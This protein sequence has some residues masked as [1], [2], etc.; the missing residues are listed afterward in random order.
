MSN[1][2][3]LWRRY[4]QKDDSQAREQLITAYAYLAKYVVDRML[5]RPSSVVGYD[6]LIGHAVVGLIDAV[7]KFDLAKNVKF[8]TY[9]IVRIRGAVL[10]ALKS[11]DWAPRSV[12]ASEQELKRTFAALEAQLGRP[13][14]DAE[15]AAEMGMDVDSLNETIADIGQS[16]MTS[17]EDLM[18]GGEDS[19]LAADADT[20][21]DPGMAAELGERKRLL[22][23][24]IN[25]LPDREKLVISLYYGDGLTLKEIAAV[26]GVTESRVC[27]LHSKAVVRLHGKLARHSDLML[28]A[29]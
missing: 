3:E 16:A 15:V 23:V 10:D 12:R 9:A 5:I 29:A 20:E 25:G 8:E 1:T 28:A 11:L 6:D 4:K 27:Q 13:A 19:G 17:L 14:T 7:E 22:A 24:A 26:L 2:I 21:S 18:A